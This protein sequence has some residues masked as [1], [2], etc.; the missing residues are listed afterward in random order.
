MRKEQ[1]RAGRNGC[2]SDYQRLW[3]TVEVRRIID[4]IRKTT[5]G[6]Q[7]HA[8]LLRMPRIRDPSS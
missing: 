1:E 7:L 5:T 3:S 8:G 6:D 2:H 4:P